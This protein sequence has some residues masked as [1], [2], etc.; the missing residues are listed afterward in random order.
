RARPDE[1]ARVVER[2][3]AEPPLASREA[4]LHALEQ[5][6]GRALRH[7][8]ARHR[9][10]RVLRIAGETERGGLWERTQVLREPL[11]D[12]GRLWLTVRTHVEYAEFPGLFTEL[13][14]EL[15]GLTAESGR[16]WSLL[17]TDRVRRAEQLDE[18]VR[19][20]KVRF[21]HSPVARVVDVEPWHR[22]PERRHALLEYDP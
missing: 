19:H 3:Q 15:G 16:Q 7:P 18:M 1:S 17:D 5:M 21:G 20:L 14:L 13:S 10:V 8:R 6:L 2:L 11:G 4:I 12:R 9:F 22:L